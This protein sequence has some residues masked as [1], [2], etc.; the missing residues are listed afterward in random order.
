LCLRFCFLVRLVVVVRE[1]SAWEEEE[2]EEDD[3]DEDDDETILLAELLVV[4]WETKECTKDVDFE[5]L[6]N[7]SSRRKAVTVCT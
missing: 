3:D 6:E 1:A 7:G 4:W 2:E 5:I